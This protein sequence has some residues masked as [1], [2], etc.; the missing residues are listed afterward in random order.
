MRTRAIRTDNPK[1]TN[2]INKSNFHNDF[3][4][5]ISCN[6]RILQT[7][8]CFNIKNEDIIFLRKYKT[9]VFTTIAASLRKDDDE[10]P[11]IYPENM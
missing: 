2:N 11:N 5:S 1:K 3:I 10:N 9:I 6:I 7:K 8:L 4:K